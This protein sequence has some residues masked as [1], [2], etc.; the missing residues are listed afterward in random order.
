MI[1]SCVCKCLHVFFIIFDQVFCVLSNC[2][3]FTCVVCESI[4]IFFFNEMFFFLVCSNVNCI[5]LYVS[6]G[7]QV[8]I[9]V[10]VFKHFLFFFHLIRCF[11]LLFSNVNCI[12]YLYFHLNPH[13]SEVPNK[14]TSN[15][16]CIWA[17][18][19]CTLGC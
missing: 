19:N 18:S 1:G 2:I 13:L 14:F 4:F 11:F 15:I 16:L 10:Y 12:P 6:G 17:L 3:S 9:T 7:R 8:P 5:I